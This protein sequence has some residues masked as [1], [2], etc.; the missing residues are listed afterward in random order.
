MHFDVSY[1][2]RIHCV[3]ETWHWV[4]AEHAA[5]SHCRYV[6]VVVDAAAV[7]FVV[8]VQ[9]RGKIRC[10]LLRHC[11]ESHCIDHHVKVLW[12]MAIGWGVTVKL[13]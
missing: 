7:V 1:W 3:Y 10:V 13:P 11:L 5:G 12:M 6:A 9:N 8:A 4:V 2:R